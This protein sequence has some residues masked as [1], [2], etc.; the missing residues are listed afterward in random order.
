MSDG[1]NGFLLNISTKETLEQ[2]LYSS[3][4]KSPNEIV[5]LRNS[6]DSNLFDFRHYKEVT[7]HFF[8]LLFLKF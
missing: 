4:M 7:N 2:S 6:I 5:K 1:K 8:E 3:L